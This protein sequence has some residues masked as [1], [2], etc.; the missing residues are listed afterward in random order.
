MSAKTI[1]IIGAYGYIGSFLSEKFLFEG[2]RVVQIGRDSLP[3]KEQLQSVDVVIYLGGL[4]RR[5]TCNTAT[6]SQL[7]QENV[8]DALNVL[9]NM[10]SNQ[11]F[12]YASS[13]SIAEGYAHVPMKEDDPIHSDQY[14]AYTKS[15]IEREKSIAEATRSRSDAPYAVGLRLGT[16]IGISPSQS[17]DFCFIKMLQDA[18][19]LQ[20]ICVQQ[21]ARP[22]L[23][24]HDLFEVVRAIVLRPQGSGRH[25]VYNI[26]SFNTTMMDIAT[27]ICKV[28]NAKLRCEYNDSEHEALQGFWVD[29]TLF[30]TEYNFK[31]QGSHASI[32][33]ALIDNIDV[34]VGKPCII[35]NSR[36]TEFVLNLGKQPLANDFIKN[37][38]DPQEHFPLPLYR[39]KECN[40]AQLNYMVPPANMF[41]NYIYASG[42]SQTMRDYFR[43]FANKCASMIPQEM[44]RC[45]TVLEI[46]CNDG[47][48]LDAFTSLGWETY[49]VD[50]SS[51][52]SEV[53]R[54]KGH[55]VTCA[56]WGCEEIHT[57][58]SSPDVIVAANVL[59]HVPNP[60]EFLQ[61]AKKV[62]TQST[63]LFVQTSQANMFENGEFDTIY[64]EHMSFFSEQ[65]FH[66]AAN[67]CGL[68]IVS[69]EKVAI[70]GTS[71]L[72][73]MRLPVM[74]T[75]VPSPQLT[76]SLTMYDVFYKNYRNRVYEKR[77]CI[78]STILDYICRG[79]TIYAYGA[80]AKGMTLLNFCGKFSKH[81]TC[82]FDDAQSKQYTYCP[83][84]RIPVVPFS[85]D[86]ITTKS[87]FIILA[88]NMKDEI[89]KK[90]ANIQQEVDVLL[91][92]PYKLIGNIKKS[93]MY[94]A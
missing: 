24:I 47:S 88:W 20:Q 34:L 15:M 32:I 64:H 55:K 6:P 27:E 73:T 7:Y 91:P 68:E 89:I 19:T 87:L 8:Q 56:F 30:Q 72:C 45:P 74:N 39:C 9:S 22:I 36:N 86:K 70:H 52:L 75:H 71:F 57:L 79:Y 4:T 10:T 25:I 38:E 33:S 93:D 35:C 29:T 18:V 11:V 94:V 69:V 84:L 60:I 12:L 28:T 13:A 46:A 14:D 54:K 63:L 51:N 49:G 2:Y 50:C 21:K 82:I 41:K 85:P 26:S 23:D 31:F 67:I 62:M 44:N 58:P 83:G 1:L 80:A 53:A 40:H 37:A 81:I 16:V 90:L 76:Q 65:S 43:S 59:A 3:S 66:R 5:S 78:I 17:H 92:F 61:A 42:T 48:Q 77:S